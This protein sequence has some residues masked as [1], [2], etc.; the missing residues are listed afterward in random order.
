[1]RRYVRTLADGSSRRAESFEEP[2]VSL[3]IALEGRVP[4]DPPVGEILS[5]DKN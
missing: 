5:A 3:L 2:V 4:A 1:M